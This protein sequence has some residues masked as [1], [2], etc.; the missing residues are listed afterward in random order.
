MDLGARIAAMVESTSYE[1]LPEEARTAAKM[2][3]LD[4][5]GVMLA[6]SGAGEDVG[7][8]VGLLDELGGNEECS[9]VA[10]GKK[11]NPA[12]AALA[13]G[14]LAHSIDYDDAHDDAFVHPSASVVPAALAAGERVH[15][16]GKELV[17]AVAVADDVMCRLGFAV[18]DPPENQGRLWML[19]V[20]L[21]SFSATVAASKMLGLSAPQVEAAL[22]IA[23]NRVGGTKELVIEPGSLRGLYAM[24]PNMTGVLAALMARAGVP[25][26]SDTFDGPAGFFSQYY[27]GVRDET[28]F[29]GLGRR[30]EGANVS[31]KPWP[32]CRFTNSHVD[33]ALG[34][35]CSHDVD[36]RR[37]ARITL[38]YAHDDAKRCLEPLE[39]R[40][41]P[42]TIPEAKLSLPFTVALALAYRT[43][44]IGSFCPQTLEDPLLADLCQKTGAAYDESLKS[45]LSKTML[46]G[47]VRVEMEDGEAFDE[48]VDVVY[49]HPRNRMRWDDLKA[50]F[51]D[52]AS[53]A[54]RPFGAA[55]AENVATMVEGL[56]TLS[57]VAVLMDAVR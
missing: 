29:A 27:G 37:I 9:V 16:S 21:G 52:C 25:G 47:R 5:L 22:G 4:T 6:G 30:F 46:P 34:I 18:S 11:S 12:L 40:R 45:T 26:L 14:A 19:P 53:H 17:T 3:V 41:R 24:F 42:R 38:Y 20:L 32:C 8:V 57:D 13:N 33:A 7:A 39:M 43:V 28:A 44:E 10:F 1:D 2:A 31:I 15:A 54:R 55:E 36:P 50:K 56:E 35:A 23:F 48:R 49:G 51:E